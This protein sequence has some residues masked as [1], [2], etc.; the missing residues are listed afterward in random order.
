[1]KKPVIAVFG[2]KNSGK[3]RFIE[4]VIDRL[5]G[6]GYRVGAI[7]HVHH[8]DFEVDKEGKDTWRYMNKGAKAVAAA[9]NKRLYINI[10]LDDYPDI[11][12]LINTIMRYVDIVIIEGFSHIVAR[13]KAILKVIIGEYPSDFVEGEKILIRDADRGKLDAY[14]KIKEKM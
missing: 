7:K 9:S 13:D 10:R 11:Y 8:G 14:M 3:T 12:E 4:Y 1:L 2:Y 5:T 6:E